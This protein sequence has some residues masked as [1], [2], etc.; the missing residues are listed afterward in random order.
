VESQALRARR[1][2]V[3]L[4]RELPYGPAACDNRRNYKA[5]HMSAPDHAQLVPKIPLAAKGAS[6]HE[7]PVPGFQYH[8]KVVFIDSNAVCGYHSPRVG[9]P[10]HAQ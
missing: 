4:A 3:D 8:Y 9:W 2:D 10:T 6:T 5:G 1:D 7:T